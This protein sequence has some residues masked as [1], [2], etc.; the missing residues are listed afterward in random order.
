M[1]AL[2]FK[3]FCLLIGFGDYVALQENNA[4]QQ[5]TFYIIFSFVYIIAGLT[6][7]AATLNLFIFRF[8]S[9]NTSSKNDAEDR[10]ISENENDTLKKEKEM[11]FD[12]EGKENS[13]YSEE[14][15]N[16]KNVL[17]KLINVAKNCFPTCSRLFCKTK[18]YNINAIVEIKEKEVNNNRL[19]VEKYQNTSN[20]RLFYATPKFEENLTE[21]NN[22]P[23]RFTNIDFCDDC[24][25]DSLSEASYSTESTS[26]PTPDMSR[27]T[28]DN[29]KP[30]DS[31]FTDQDGEK[32]ENNEKARN[33]NLMTENKIEQIR[34]KAQVPNLES[35]P[36]HF[37]KGFDESKIHIENELS[38]SAN[39]KKMFFRNNR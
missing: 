24:K 3:C 7:F 25:N 34:E 38:S 32:K 9:S 13:S 30:I 19:F 23:S 35:G 11:S 31:D 39:A 22:I 36:I 10:E 15:S 27:R 37:P 26:C 6:V 21:R 2:N 18:S 12:S 16:Y 28:N 4:L 14:N 20:H 8:E 17:L 33:N 5:D 1:F 29:E